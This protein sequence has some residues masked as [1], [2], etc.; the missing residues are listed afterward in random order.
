MIPAARH[1]NSGA[2]NV[3]TRWTNFDNEDLFNKNMSGG[4]P[5]RLMKKYGWDDVDKIV[6]QYNSHGFRTA[7]FDNTRSGLAL[8]CSFTQGTGLPVENIWPSVLSRLLDFPIWN[9][10]VIGSST[11][12]CF[13]LLDHYLNY[14]NIEF[15]VVCTPHKT[16][17]EFFDIDGLQ[18]VL[19]ELNTPEY[20][21]PY[22]KHWLSND[23]NAITNQ[24]KNLLAMQKLCDDKKINFVQFDC[25]NFIML[26]LA[27][28]LT[29]P[30]VESHKHFAEEIF[31]NYDYSNR[32]SSS[33]NS[34]Y[35]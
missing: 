28:D 31:K 30:G 33:K 21:M 11:D 9:L 19:P 8:G 4:R 15:V 22:Y 1:I 29:H 34:R 14:L 26:D 13:R 20:A 35:S 27:R 32:I 17:F 24:R 3:T 5:L 10:G 2:S 7:E 12:S 23:Q 18:C 25:T 6:Y 16:R